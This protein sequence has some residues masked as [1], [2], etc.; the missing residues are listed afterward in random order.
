MTNFNKN[1]AS[2]QQLD[3]FDSLPNK[4]YCMDDVPG[5]MLIRTKAIAVNKPYI[6]VNPPL[7]TIYFV[8]DVDQEDSVWSWFDAN[9]L[10]RYGRHK[11]LKM[12]VAIIA[13]NLNC[14]SAQ[15]NLQVSKR[16]SMHRRFTTPTRSS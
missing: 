10:N 12:D 16:S 7:M 5:S 15:V 1:T 3:L 2:K 13:T 14:Q 9:L 8:F 6:Q 11:T 4:P